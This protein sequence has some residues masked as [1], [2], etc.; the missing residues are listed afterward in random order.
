MSIVFF[1][2]NAIVKNINRNLNKQIGIIS[3][4]QQGYKHETS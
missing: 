3:I 4:Q 1:N 2:H